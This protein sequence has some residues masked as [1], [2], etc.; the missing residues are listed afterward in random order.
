M[1]FPMPITGYAGAVLGYA[2]VPLSETAMT[3]PIVFD[4]ETEG[5]ANLTGYAVIDGPGL[6]SNPVSSTDPRTFRLDNL[7]Q[8]QL[9]IGGAV[10]PNGLIITTGAVTTEDD[11]QTDADESAA[12]CPVISGTPNIART[13]YYF[14]VKDNGTDAVPRYST[15]YLRVTVR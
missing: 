5:Y 6:L 4:G 7:V 8:K 14:I 10:G 13:D 9:T 1:V 12:F 15:G 2:N 3:E 11:D